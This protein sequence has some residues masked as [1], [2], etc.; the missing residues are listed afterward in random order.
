MY[1]KAGNFKCATYVRPPVGDGVAELGD[2]L[3]RIDQALGLGPSLFPGRVHVAHGAAR[4]VAGAALLEDLAHEALAQ[5]PREVGPA[6]QVGLA[7]V[8]R[9][10]FR[11]G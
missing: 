8:G 10:E 6:A 7:H 1:N 3:L 11:L 4:G 5:T 9:L 2:L